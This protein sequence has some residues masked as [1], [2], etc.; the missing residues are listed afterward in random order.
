METYTLDLVRGLLPLLTESPIIITKKF[1]ENIE[2]IDKVH[3]FKINL[4]LI[5][6]FLRDLYFSWRAKKII[7]KNKVDIVI[8]C[9]RN[10]INDVVMCGGTH[11]GYVLSKK[12]RTIKDIRLEKTEEIQN[13]KASLI[14]AHSELM[15]K[16]LI[17]LYGLDTK[18][19]QVL[20]PP[21]RLDKFSPVSLSQKIELRK[22]FGLSE[23]RIYFLFV[24]SS[25]ERKGFELL[26]HYF[27][28][29]QLP[30]TLLVVGK[31]I[32]SGLKNIHYFGRTKEIQELYRAV[33]FT[34]LASKYE[35]FGLA[36]IESVACHTPVVISDKL[37][38]KDV[39]SDQWKYVFKSDS[40]NS[41][42]EIITRAV[43]Q[44]SKKAEIQKKPLQPFL[45]DLSVEHHIDEVY[46]ELLQIKSVKS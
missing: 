30:V 7:K 37:G 10:T 17:N 45:V 8:G 21:V 5:P 15:K 20:Y 38:C 23:K 46:K 12:R 33:D 35:P 39:I 32:E 2:L 27:T 31:P 44:L 28:N 42:K 14:I 36:A 41:F 1:D 19:I 43:N 6:P 26:K 11:K 3:L 22:K 13:K 40:E 29:S 9:C 25:H 18:K 16:E 34:V 4:S 24:S